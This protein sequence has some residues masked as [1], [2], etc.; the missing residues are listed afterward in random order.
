MGQ[1]DEQTQPQ[2]FWNFSVPS[3]LS[4]TNYAYL[5]GNSEQ[6]FLPWNPCLAP[7]EKVGCLWD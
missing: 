4:I 3:M 5:L 1:K 2:P 7:K 6:S